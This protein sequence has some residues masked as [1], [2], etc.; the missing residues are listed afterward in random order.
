M[1]GE[2]NTRILL[3]GLAVRVNDTQKAARCIA[4]PSTFYRSIGNLFDEAN[5]IQGLAEVAKAEGREEEA[6]AFQTEADL[7]YSQSR[8]A[9]RSA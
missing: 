9:R 4:K 7:L 5:A 6:T 2:A 3:A 8:D 1:R